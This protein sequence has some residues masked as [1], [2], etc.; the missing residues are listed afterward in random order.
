MLHVFDA[1]FDFVF[2]GPLLLAIRAVRKSIDACLLAHEN[3]QSKLP[4]LIV[5]SPEAQVVFVLQLEGLCG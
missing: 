5:F 1:T 3:L 2:F 4:T